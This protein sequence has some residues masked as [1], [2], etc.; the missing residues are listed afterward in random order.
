MSIPVTMRAIIR[1]GNAFPNWTEELNTT[2]MNVDQSDSGQYDTS[3]LAMERFSREGTNDGL[4][5]SSSF[6]IMQDLVKGHLTSVPN[7]GA[8]LVSIENILDGITALSNQ[9]DEWAVIFSKHR[10]K[11]MRKLEFIRSADKHILQIF[12]LYHRGALVA[13][14][15]Q[16][17]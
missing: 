10:I 2:A 14:T 6:G 16:L 13:M 4:L 15:K 12:C 11:K 7:E 8:A 9:K 17:L 1:Q 5:S 3:V